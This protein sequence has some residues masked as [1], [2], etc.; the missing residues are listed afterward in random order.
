MW[1]IFVVLIRRLDSL[2]H[3]LQSLLSFF[4][5]HLYHL[6]EQLVSGQFQA[7]K[8]AL[9]IRIFSR[10]RVRKDDLILTA[11]LRD[12]FLL[13]FGRFP[14][15]EFGFNLHIDLDAKTTYSTLS[16]RRRFHT[17]EPWLRFW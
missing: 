3:S 1:P 7:V 4:A 6:Y 17:S 8:N 11:A 16:S 13:S 14:L 9:K 12:H 5:S 15:P 10:E 2:D